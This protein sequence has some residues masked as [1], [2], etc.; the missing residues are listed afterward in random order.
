[1]KVKQKSLSMQIPMG[2]LVLILRTCYSG[3]LDFQNDIL[4]SLSGYIVIE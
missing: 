4:L 1:M 3:L 2:F